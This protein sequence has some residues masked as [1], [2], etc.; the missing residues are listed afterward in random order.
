MVQSSDS[1]GE[2]GH[3]VESRRAAVDDLLNELGKGS[4]VCPVLGESL[5][6]CIGRNFSGQQEP[7]KSF[8]EWFRAAWGLGQLSLTFR[9]GLA[10]ETDALLF[11]R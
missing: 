6:L 11:R 9:N 3:W 5:D 1:H 4:P 7:E 8:W 2:L 10:T